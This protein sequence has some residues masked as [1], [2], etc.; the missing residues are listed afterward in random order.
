ML[1][2]QCSL[3]AHQQQGHRQRSATSP[4]RAFIPGV[5]KLPGWQSSFP[6]E[7]TS[8]SLWTSKGGEILFSARVEAVPSSEETHMRVS[9]PQG[10]VFITVLPKHLLP[11]ALCA[12]HPFLLRS[13]SHSSLQT[14]DVLHPTAVVWSAERPLPQALH[15]CVPLIG[16]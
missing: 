13:R 10:S 5:K 3:L 7:V 4:G 6:Q 2:V 9:L 14:G 16:Q 8:T 12:S 11:Q 1:S 15:P